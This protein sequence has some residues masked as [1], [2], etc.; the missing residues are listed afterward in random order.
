MRPYRRVDIGLSK[1]LMSN[2]KPMAENNPFRHFRNIWV[3]LEVFNLLDINNTISH[4]W[5]TDIRG[6]QYAVPNYLTGRR[7]NLKLI[8]RF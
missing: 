3:T 2:E 8:A 4:T 7:V 6:W 1:R 5:V